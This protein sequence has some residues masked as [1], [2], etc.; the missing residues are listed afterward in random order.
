[1]AE[2]TFQL[3]YDGPALRENRMNVRDLAPALLALG[4]LVAEA[5][6]IVNPEQPPDSLQIRATEPG[7]FV[8][9]L[10]IVQEGIRA[11]VDM[12][13]SESATALANLKELLLVP[14]AGGVI[15]VIKG[16]RGRRVVDQK[17][18]LDGTVTLT[19][20]DGTT[21]SV[22]LATL[23]LYRDVSIRQHVR[24][25]LAPLEQDGID[26]VRSIQDV[27]REV[28][29]EVAT[30]DLPSFEVQE[31]RQV[32]DQTQL[33]MSLEI[34]APS[35]AENNK[36]RLN[37]GTATFWATIADS[38]FLNRVDQRAEVF[39]KGDILRCRVLFQQFRTDS[40]LQSDRIV[41]QVIDHIPA[42][43]PIELPIDID[44]PRDDA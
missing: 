20:N 16:I 30:D 21:L 9:D 33:T 41:E 3:T 42:S 24:E 12:F 11:V 39:G 23:G 19:L 5:N 10:T 32:L 25:V 44:L 6:Q 14:S 40:G 15:W 2:T 22:P 35:F 36:W 43:R 27:D 13:S 34:V 29:L 37:D 18:G 26:E 28:V 7:S 4:E 8:V 31:A 17:P 1:M 38:A